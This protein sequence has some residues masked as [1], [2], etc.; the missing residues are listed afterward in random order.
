MPWVGER[1]RDGVERAAL[2]RRPA[3]PCEP[4]RRARRD[5]CW[6]ARRAGRLGDATRKRDRGR[7]DGRGVDRPTCADQRHEGGRSGQHAHRGVHRLELELAEGLLEARHAAPAEVTRQPPPDPGAIHDVAKLPEDVA[8]IG[9]ELHPQPAVA[10]LARGPQVL[11]PAD[12]VAKRD[13]RVAR[14]G[15]AQAL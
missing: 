4:A 12:G 9:V 13:P 2:R 5:R 15:Q 10:Q 7:L 8:A 14:G 6:I 3:D 1:R 11:E